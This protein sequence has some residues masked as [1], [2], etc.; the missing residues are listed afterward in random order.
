MKTTE[1]SAAFT[2]VL[3]L[4]AHE[5]AALILLSQAPIDTMMRN[6]DLAALERE[7][8]AALTKLE[9]GVSRFAVTREGRAVLRALGIH[10]DMEDQGPAAGP[11]PAR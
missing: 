1:R 11:Y 4:S 3:Q 9:S 2:G 10:G 8:L 5:M 7:G 6:P